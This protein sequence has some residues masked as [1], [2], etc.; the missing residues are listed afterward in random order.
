MAQIHGCESVEIASDQVRVHVTLVGGMSTAVFQVEGR[1]VSPYSLS[2]WKPSEVSPDLPGL[3]RVLRGEFL[4]LPF[5]PQTDGPPHGAGA[6]EEWSVKSHDATSLDLAMHA[7]DTGASLVKSYQVREGESAIYYDYRISGLSGSWSYGTHPILDASKLPEG[8]ARVSVS[9]FRMASVYPGWFSNPDAGERQALQPSARFDDLT[10]VPLLAGGTTDLTRWP[11]RRGFDDL[12]MMV[13]EP[14]TESQP[15]AWS[16]VVMDGYVWIAL[17]SPADFPATLF[18]MS[19]GGRDA[20]PWN[21]R[22]LGR[23]GIEEVCS[24]FCDSVDR[25]REDLLANEGIPTTREF[26]AHE[27]C[28]LGMIHLVASVPK[29]FDLVKSVTPVGD[30]TVRI[31][32]SHGTQVESSVNWKHLFT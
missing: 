20:E 11:A 9:P 4:C 7:A 19:N 5:G 23:I 32:D 17:K 29:G 26:H 8:S 25:S 30:S 3:L 27:T 6:N 15:F 13:N 2:P 22:H 14:A 21:G 24:H 1:E 10:A 12:V 16:A 28:R 31:T 18:W